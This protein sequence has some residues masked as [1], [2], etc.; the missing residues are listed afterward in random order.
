MLEFL[1]RAD[2]QVKIRGFRIEPGEIEA[3]LTRHAGGRAGGGD[4][5]R[6][7]AGRQAAG[8]LRGRGAPIKRSTPR[9]CARIVAARLPDYMVPAAFVRAGRLPLTANGKLD[10]Q[11]LARAA[12]SRRATRRR[13]PRTPPEEALA[14]L[15]AEVLGLDAGR[16]RRQLLRARRRQHHVDPAGEP[17]APDRA[18]DHPARGVPAS[19]GRGA[20][21]RRPPSGRGQRPH[22]LRSAARG[23]VAGRDR[24][25]AELASADRGYAPAVA[26]AGGASV[27]CAL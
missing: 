11:A 13:A 9:R 1:G 25:T 5:A 4:R 15:F 8:R 19:N 21:G 26:L 22:V 16:H 6:G 14:R 10:R 12:T 17:G 7:P 24:A 3:A 18:R 20:G 27:P 2:S 23:V